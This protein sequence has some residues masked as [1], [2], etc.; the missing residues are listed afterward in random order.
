MRRA[1]TS[2]SGKAAITHRFERIL[3][4]GDV[5]DEAIKEALPDRCYNY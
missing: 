1:E 4:S 5:T 2:I 3:G